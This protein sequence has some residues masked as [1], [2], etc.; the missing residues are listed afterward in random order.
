MKPGDSVQGYFPWLTG[1][2]KGI[3]VEKRIPRV[4]EYYF[5]KLRNG[6]IVCRAAGVLSSRDAMREFW[7]IQLLD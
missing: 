3:I 6:E 2:R 7:I 4:G 1:V 5:N